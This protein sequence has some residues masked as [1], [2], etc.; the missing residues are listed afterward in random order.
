VKD[1]NLNT[2]DVLEIRN[3]N[4]K[5]KK[6]VQR[7]C[8]LTMITHSTLL[9]GNQSFNFCKEITTSTKLDNVVR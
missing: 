2:Q 7:G 6:L 9:I 3:D 1:V 4:N 8:D 5:R